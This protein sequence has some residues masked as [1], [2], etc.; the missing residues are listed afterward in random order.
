MTS[1]C[2]GRGCVRMAKPVE[3]KRPITTPAVNKMT[4]LLMPFTI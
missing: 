4:V 3:I 1:F 2:V